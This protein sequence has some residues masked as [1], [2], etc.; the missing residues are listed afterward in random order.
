M[1]P[2]AFWLN[3]FCRRLRNNDASIQTVCP[4]CPIGDYGMM[5]ISNAMNNNSVVQSLELMRPKLGRQ[6]LERLVHLIRTNPSL[7]RVRI[8]QI[9]R[10]SEELY[11]SLFQALLPLSINEPTPAVGLKVLELS[12]ATITASAAF[13]LRKVLELENCPLVELRLTNCKWE[14]LAKKELILGLLG[15]RSLSVLSLASCRISNALCM[16]LA[17]ALGN[18]PKLQELDLHDNDVG[19]IGCCVLV[20]SLLAT[21]NVTLKRLVLSFN[22]I[23]AEGAGYLGQRLPQLQGLHEI[24]LDANPINVSGLLSLRDGV[25]QNLTIHEFSLGSDM[26]QLNTQAAEEMDFLLELN[27]IGCRR[28]LLR[29]EIPLPLWSYA[30][31]RLAENKDQG[32]SAVNYFLQERPDLL[33]DIIPEAIGSIA[34]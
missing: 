28:S 23:G 1:S 20:E 19:D 2:V 31:N 24:K 33:R 27:R 6:G 4:P 12:G 3:E 16:A 17:A 26:K 30:L 7:R 34:A 9:R 5:M 21:A 11:E 15:N 32:F 13:I 18:H 8:D 10:R 22:R 29:D 25:R 14:P